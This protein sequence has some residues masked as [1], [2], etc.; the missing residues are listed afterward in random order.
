MTKPDK[1]TILNYFNGRLNPKEEADLLGWIRESE[2][3]RN[4]FIAAREGLVPEQMDHPLLKRSLAVMKNKLVL[5][6]RFRTAVPGNK[7]RKIGLSFTRIAAMLLLALVMGGLAVWL[8]MD[9]PVLQPD[10]VWFE[11]R[12]PRGE[13]SQLLLP[14]GSRVW[15]NAE[16]M[17][18]F[19]SDFME[20]NRTVRLQGEAYFEVAEQKGNHF[21]VFTNDYAIRVM[22]TCFNVMAYPD[23]NRTETSLLEGRVEIRKGKELVYMN[24]GQTLI[25]KDEEFF[26]E[27]SNVEKSASWKDDIFDF[28]RISFREL[29]LRLERWY[30]VKIEIGTPELNEIVYSG[31]FK[32]EETIDQVLNT[33]KLTTPIYYTREGFR[34]FKI[35]LK[36]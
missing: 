8:V 20:G 13:K 9:P 11:N 1:Q 34:K 25:F 3:N 32:N 5:K 23:F 35:K 30:D 4:Y 16:S 26:V 28:D 33:L 10:T 2:V 24:P 36:N 22:G 6:A 19:P 27:T 7:M 14:D 18:S 12:V 31:V 29:V 15:M 21:T 17:L